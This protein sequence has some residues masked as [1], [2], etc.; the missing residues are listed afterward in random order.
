MNIGVHVSRG[1][2]ISERDD[3]AVPRTIPRLWLLFFVYS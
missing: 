3:A 1:F 2:Y